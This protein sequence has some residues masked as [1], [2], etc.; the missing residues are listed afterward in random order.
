[1]KIFARFNSAKEHTDLVHSIL[2]ERLLHETIQQLKFFRSKGLITFN[3]IEKFIEA[4]KLKSK[5]QGSNAFAAGRANVAVVEETAVVAK[6]GA[7]GQSHSRK[8][9]ST[10]QQ[11][12][13]GNGNQVLKGSYQQLEADPKWASLSKKER[14]FCV[15]MMMKPSNF[16]VIKVQI[17][18]EIVARRKITTQ[19]LES[20]QYK[21]K[22]ISQQTRNQIPTLYE[23][24]INSNIISYF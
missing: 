6:D 16:N 20:L 10:Q 14:Q 24:L 21:N 18:K 7:Q 4:Q 17:Q 22:N 11:V 8:R 3:A 5:N 15:E 13:T 1:M 12:N 9:G 2:R 19:F 23:F